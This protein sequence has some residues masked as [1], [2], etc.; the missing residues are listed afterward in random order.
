MSI[1]NS[2]RSFGDVKSI[3]NNII[4][5]S[6]ASNITLQLTRIGKMLDES[7]LKFTKR[8]LIIQ[9]ELEEM[10]REFVG[11]VAI[12]SEYLN[13]TKKE[14]RYEKYDSFNQGKYSNLSNIP[15]MPNYEQKAIL[16]GEKNNKSYSR[17]NNNL[18]NLSVN[19]HRYNNYSIYHN[20]NSNSISSRVYS[21]DMRSI[22]SSS[23]KSL[24]DDKKYN[25][26]NK[27]NYKSKIRNEAIKYNNYH[28]KKDEILDSLPDNKTKGIFLL[29]DSKVL[30]Y[31]DK[32]KLLF[33]KKF[34]FK[35]IH[36]RDILIDELKEVQDKIQVL[37][38]KELNEEDEKIINKIM[39]YP[40][41]TAKTGLNYL[42]FDRENELLNNENEVNLILLKMIYSCLNEINFSN[43]IKEGYEYLFKKYEVNSIKN[44]FLDVIYKKIFNDSLK[45]KTNKKAEKIIN[46]INEN[47]TLMTTNLIGNTNK[48]FNYV[49]FSLDEICEFLKEI[50]GLDKEMKKNILN[51]IELKNLIEKEQK[52]KN[53]LQR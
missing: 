31:E 46:D 33:T 48:I 22:K 35:N 10:K 15:L 30:S 27:K 52:I 14:I 53:N 28:I 25:S 38:N 3:K 6:E 50:K 21:P 26:Y 23:T 1:K 42:T 34:I 51:K 41:K 4:T 11:N 13:L 32:I 29:I 17:F 18:N 8:Y 39:S 5:A 24:R 2:L 20:K 9:T 19:S 7:V 40:S 45:D 12:I 16:K 49:C 37:K 44:L 36:P 43:N 47:K